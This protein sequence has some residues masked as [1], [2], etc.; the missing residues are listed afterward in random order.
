MWH[1]L[2]FSLRSV[3]LSGICS[4]NVCHHLE[5]QMQTLFLAGWGRTAE[6][7]RQN[8]CPRD[9]TRRLAE[10]ARAGLE[11]AAPFSV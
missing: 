3:S 7:H 10:E 2:F 8:P 5:N 4:E 11:A 1:L 6:T 9:S